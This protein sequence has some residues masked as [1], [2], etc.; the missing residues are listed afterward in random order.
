MIDWK[1]LL[2][3]AQDFLGRGNIPPSEWSFGGGTALMLHYW[4]RESDDIEIFIKDAQLITRLTPRLNDY[5]EERVDDYVEMSNFVKLRIG[6]QEI[7]F[8]VAPFLTPD[9][10]VVMELNSKPVNLET[11]SEIVVKK[12]FY[13][14]ESLKA[15]DFFD[16]ACVF[17]RNKNE[18]LRNLQIF[19]GKLPA[20]K[21][22]LNKIEPYLSEELK[23]LRILDT[24]IKTLSSCFQFLEECERIPAKTRK[25]SPVGPG[26][27]HDRR[28]A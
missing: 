21:E 7:D 2:R 11:P 9:P 25:I 10:V 1:E 17:D 24:S 8:I 15:R 12:I 4:H 3:L 6:G 13:R 28:R 14:S 27:R 18:L 19:Q 16:L 26:S 20:L 23:A 5:V 22:R